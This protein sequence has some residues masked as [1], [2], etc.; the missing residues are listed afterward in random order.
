VLALWGQSGIFDITR[1]TIMF[2]VETARNPARNFRLDEQRAK[3]GCSFWANAAFISGNNSRWSGVR[4]HLKRDTLARQ[5][6][7]TQRNKEAV[8]RN[9]GKL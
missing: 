8:L 6:L 1:P 2:Q 7:S 3:S 5:A 4:W 9:E